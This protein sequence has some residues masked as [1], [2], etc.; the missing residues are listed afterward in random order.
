MDDSLPRPALQAETPEPGPADTTA[1]TLGFGLDFAALYDKGGLARVDAAFLDHLRGTDAGL[2]DRLA[3]AR[4][5]PDTLDRKAESALILDL[6]PH[7]ED[8]LGLLFGIGAAIRAKA[9]EHD[10]LA[11][12]FACKRLFVQRIA[13]KKVKP[14]AAAALDGPA[15][16][17]DLAAR[18]GGPVTETRFADQVMAWMEDEAAHADDL[19]LAMRFAAWAGLTP[20]GRAR[21]ADGVLFKQPKKNDPMALIPLEADPDGAL[22]R[23]R[24]PAHHQRRREGFALTDP[25]AD[26]VKGLDEAHYCIFCHHQGNDSCSTG[27]KDRKTGAVQVNA[28]GRE[29]LGC[30]LEEKISEMHEA[31]TKGGFVGA[32]GIITIDNP[33]CAGTGHRICNDCMVACIYQKQKRD[34]VNIP[35]AETRILKDVLALPWGFEVY[36]LLTRWNPLNIRRP[37]PRPDTGKRVLVVGL[38]PAGYSLAHHLMNDGHDVVGIDGLKI[39]PLDPALSGV[40][41]LG[42]RVPFTPVRDVEALREPLESRVMGGFGGVAEYGITVRWDKNFLTVIRLLL[43]R[44][45]EFAM[46]GGVRYGST[47]PPEAAYAMGF[48]HVALCMGAG[49]PTIVP[50]EN[51]LARGVRQASDFLMALQLTGAA[52]AD[53]VANLQLRLPVVV[54]GGGLTAV[55]ATTEALAYYPV[56]VEK[57][58]ARHEALVAERGEAAV[59]A[60]W[61]EEERTIMDEFLAHGRAIRAERAAAAA[62]G[63]EPRIR[64]LLQ[65][66]GGS[67]IVYRRRLTDSPAYRN[68]HEEVEKAL[69][70]GITVA[71]LW[72]PVRVELDRFGHAEGLLVEHR[73][74]GERRTIPARSIIVAAGTVP[75]TTLAREHEGQF[76]LDG[77]FFQAVDETGAPVSPE[78]RAKPAKADVLMAVNDDG[79]SMSFL[80]DLHPSFA[81]NV[82][83][84]FASALRAY[85]VISRALDRRPAGTEARDRL[86][87]RLNAA[88]RPVVH[89]VERLTPTIVEVVVRAPLAA[90]GFHPGQ[91]YRL[92]NFERFAPHADGTLLAMEGLALT[93]AWVDR[94]AG[95][96]SM[97]VLE[98][99]GSSDLCALLK[100][101][102]PVVVMGPTGAPTEIPAGETVLLAGGGL[103]NAVLFSIGTALRAAGSKVLYFAGYKAMR[104]RFKVDDI[105][106]AADVVVWCC[107]EGPGFTPARPQDKAFVGNIVQAMVAYGDGTLGETTVPLS[108]VDRVIAIGSDRMMQAVGTARHDVLAPFLKPGNLG[109][110]SINSPMQCMMKEIC[111]Q[112]LQPHVDPVT[113]RQTIVF[114]CFNQDQSLDTVDF[115]ALHERLGQNTAQEKLTAA[116]ID[117][118]LHTLGARADQAAE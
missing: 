104:D 1:L 88:L 32:L 110:G 27:L 24:L 64:E 57:I 29:M 118:C 85:P 89:S 97:I 102:E 63:R 78:R 11:V 69:E 23:V 21:S 49:K 117:R 51:G 26:L 55:D 109:I 82:V 39:E 67:G 19:D 41:A 66:W 44:R 71:E 103:G 75:N 116:W 62:E 84:A 37:L 100:P 14:D 79:T 70:E 6:A 93:G 112:C 50:M 115:K 48:D 31:K 101:G 10:R 15:L 56:Q 92:Q 111:A 9:A 16:E 25:G 30:P 106:D 54:I 42:T 74:T 4:Q 33:L 73:E 8:F 35:E 113:G 20:E 90:Q 2:A 105:H 60:R 43:E 38:G 94:E 46:I 98:M 80:G 108:D 114:S 5:A 18:L 77:K 52:R 99:G 13:F 107:D 53:S 40:D 68:N 28:L 61:S 47:L 83:T 91:F 65:S 3:A 7:L 17:A 34:P 76:A 59:R 22:P 81:G 87:A 95:L 58:L 36:S 72:S 45:A 86:F 12:L 96:L